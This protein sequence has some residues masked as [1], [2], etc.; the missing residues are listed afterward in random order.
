M[1]RENLIARI[2]EGA[3]RLQSYRTVDAKRLSRPYAEGKWNGVQIISHLADTDTVLFYRFLKGAAEA[4]S[5]IVMFNQ[6]A[7][8]DELMG[9]DRPISLSL[10]IIEAVRAGF[11]HHLRVLPANVLARISTHPERGPVT[12]FD[13]AE[14]AAKHT[15]HH[16]EQLDAIRDG[17]TWE[18]GP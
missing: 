18:P 2:E 1:D 6:D 12:P 9:A 8:V 7:W 10:S 14:T 17:R 3:N 16:L 5:Q 11:V 13:M 4:G 15:L